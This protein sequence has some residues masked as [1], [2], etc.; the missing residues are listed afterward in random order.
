MCHPSCGFKASAFDNVCCHQLEHRV[1]TQI[2]TFSTPNLLFLELC[3][4]AIMLHPIVAITFFPLSAHNKQSLAVDASVCILL[5]R[6]NKLAELGCPSRCL[7]L[8]RY[9]DFNTL[10][11]P[12]LVCIL[13]SAQFHSGCTNRLI[14]TAVSTIGKRRWLVCKK[15]ML[16]F[17]NRRLATTRWFTAESSGGEN[18]I[19]YYNIPCGFKI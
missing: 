10:L 7:S 8:P 11:P 1:I 19:S 5:W 2:R 14:P 16:K 9:L 13:A 6:I 18:E 15:K 17:Y 12:I 4:F 3:A